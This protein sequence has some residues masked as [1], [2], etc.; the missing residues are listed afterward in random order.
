V[1]SIPAIGSVRVSQADALDAEGRIPVFVEV[2]ERLPRVI[3]FSAGFSTLDGPSV[4][5]YWEH[6]NLF[7][8]AEQLRLEG[9]LFIAPRNDGTRLRSFQD[10][11]PSDVGGRF[12]ATFIKPAL[13]GTRNDLIA[14]VMAERDRTGGDRFGG[15]TVR[16]VQG[17]I[18][19]RHRISD[20]FFV[21]GGVRAERGQTSDVISNIDYF[22]VG[23]PVSVAYDS[24][25]NPLDP[26]RGVKIVGSATPYPEFLGSTVGFAEAR[27]QASTYLALDDDARFVLAARA[28]I[29]TLG[30]PGLDEIPANH[31]F[32]AGGAASVRG[33]RRQSLGPTGP[34]GFVVGGRS[35]LEASFEA[36]IKIT[37]TIGIV[38]FF[39]AGNAFESSFPNLKDKLYK[40][41]GLGLRYYT[42]IGPIRADVAFPLDRRPGDTP[43]SLYISIGQAF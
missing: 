36:R 27:L 10:I 39:D 37:D 13:G 20:T 11:L 5:G 24:T 17:A 35:L 16:D 31:R 23:L 1:A 33:Y 15:Y 43:A 32:Y 34:F 9:S 26:T 18:S 6:R 3:G 19:I 30:G 14:E 25:D 40:S 41:V 28:A 29:G 21:Q 2:G 4:R 12:R 8:G 38:P 22:I 7:G 42:P